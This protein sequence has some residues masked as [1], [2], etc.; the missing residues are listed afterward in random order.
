MALLAAAFEQSHAATCITTADLD[1]PGP[2]IVAVNPA[3]CAMTGYVGGDVIGQTPR[4]MQGPLTDRVVLDRL[5]RDLEAGR[6]FVGETVNY[7]A[8]GSPFLI[9]WRI[10]PIVGA[11]GRPTHYVATQDDV[12]RLRRAEAVAAALEAIDLS[13]PEAVVGPRAGRLDR[14][15]ATVAAAAAG[16]LPGGLAVLSA[17]DA[18]HPRQA[19]V[20]GASGVVDDDVWTWLDSAPTGR[21]VEWRGGFAHVVPFEGPG[22]FRGRLAGVGM[23]AAEAAFLDELGLQRVAGHL[24]PVLGAAAHTV[25]QRAALVEL[26]RD[27][28]P[29]AGD[30]PAGLDLAVRYEPAVDD[31]AVG[32]DWYDAVA[33]GERVVVTVG[34]VEGSGVRAAAAV[35]RIRA[36][37]RSLVPGRA[38]DDVVGGLD[39]YASDHGIF[40]TCLV[41]ELGPGGRLSVASAGHLPPVVR[42]ADGARVVALEPGPPLGAGLPVPWTVTGTDVG[43]A[44]VVAFTDGAVERRGEVI[45]DGIERIRA[46]VAAAPPE[47]EALCDAVLAGLDRDAGPAASATDDR[48][49][50][51]FRPHPH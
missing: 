27:A 47:P 16:I 17:V 43:A 50:L 24:G 36:V 41:L 21:L 37:F 31:L 15:A 25:R 14:V 12:T 51:A 39:R 29:R 28:L 10:D 3:Y 5:R 46:L 22:G 30:V 33:D 40:A 8:D 23:S 26:Q 45:D 34:D 49:L 32:G 38:V 19:P 1:Q 11:D 2:R 35:G 44:S 13:W 6:T 42:S 20:A 18:E 7:R 48:V 9:A 4:I